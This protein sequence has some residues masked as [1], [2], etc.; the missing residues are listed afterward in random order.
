MLLAHP[1]KGVIFGALIAYSSGKGLT[2]KKYSKIIRRYDV[3]GPDSFYTTSSVKCVVEYA[4]LRIKRRFYAMT[5]LDVILSTILVV[6]YLACLFTVCALTFRK[7]YFLLGIIGI[8]IPVLWLIGAILPAK[9]GSSY[10][11]RYDE[12]QAAI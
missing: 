10:S 1:P 7:G 8:F 6:I 3:Q 11:Q 2:Q 5:L 12:H 4:K 9:P